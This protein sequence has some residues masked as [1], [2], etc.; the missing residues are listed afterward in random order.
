M[1]TSFKVNT[2]FSAL[3]YVVLVDQIA[4]QHFDNV[5]YAPHLGLLNTMKIFYDNCVTESPLDAEIRNAENEISNLAAVTTL[6]SNSDFIEAFNTALVTDCRKFD[7]ANAY[8]DAMK[9]VDN[10]KS[11]MWT[12][13]N[14]AQNA[15]NGLVA[16][17][18]PALTPENLAAMQKIA[19]GI[20]ENTPTAEAVVKAYADSELLKARVVNKE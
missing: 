3:D 18:A 20:T 11:S 14:I 5:E 2:A 19:K 1:N 8:A 7:F 16:K 15:M 4:A 6:A 17:I 13:L 10:Q 9:I 12:L